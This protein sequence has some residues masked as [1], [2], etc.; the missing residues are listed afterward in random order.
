MKHFTTLLAGL[1]CVSS[2]MAGTSG[3]KN[4]STAPVAAAIANT[5]PARAAKGRVTGP[6]PEYKWTNVKIV[7]GGYVTGLYFHPK[8]QNLMYART[9][10][11]GA[12]R[13]GPN[14]S[15]WMPLL[16]FTPKARWW[17]CGVEAIGLDPT[18]PDKLYIAVGEYTNNWD[19]HGAMLIS[20]DQGN[21]FTVIPLPFKNGSNELGRETGDRIAVDAN[22]PSVIYFGTR[23][24]GLQVST[25]S[26]ATWTQAAGLPVTATVNGNGVVAVLPVQASG[27]SGSASPAVYA[28]TGGTGTG[29]DPQAIYVSANGGTAAGKWIAVNGQPTFADKPLAPIQARLGPNRAI[30]IL[31]GDQP[32]PNTM[33]RSELW[34]FVPGADWTTGTWTEIA[35]PNQNLGINNSNGYAGIAVDQNHAGHLLLST[36]DQY[37]PTGDVVYRTTDDGATWRDVSSAK[38]SNESASPGLATHD[39]SLSP[40]VAYG[41]STVSTGNWATTVAIDPFNPDHAIYGTG[42]TVWATTNLTSADPSASSTGIVHWTVGGNGI[43]E[44]EVLGLWA[45]PSGKTI[46]LSSIGDVYGFAHQDLTISP[47]QMFSNPAAVPSSMDFEQKTPTTVVRVT[48]GTDGTAPIGA[49]SNDGGLAWTAFPA[50]PPGTKGGGT[51]AIAPDGSSMVWATEDTQSVWFSTNLGRSWTASTGINAQA[52]VASD[53]VRAGVFYGFSNGTLSMSTDGGA[54]FTTIQSGLPANG[55]LSV[56]PDTQGDVW[57][58]GQESGLYSNSGTIAL[59]TLTA[60]AG[61]QDAYHLGFGKSAAGSAKPTLYLDGQIAGVWGL[62]RSTDSGATWVEINDPAHQWGGFS[63]VCGDMRTFGTVYLGTSGGRGIIWGTSGI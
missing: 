57:L 31:Y 1:V 54:T 39:A 12:Y 33:T 3:S 52:R 44:S 5:A 48:D 8:Q 13:W 43:E 6:A 58:A 29:G 4:A 38:M 24:A 41:R 17:Q 47:P 7:G 60:V 23:V 11:G 9:D 56:L 51:I 14:D 25:N 63:A 45:P 10:I 55:T 18:D 32:G 34:K 42:Q 21:T 2:Q 16:D 20:N 36:L 49:I 37:S 62:Y 22:M 35:L 50:M 19:G 53:R 46:L 26:G 15:E 40:Y 61:V 27:S 59:P 28:I 30:Y